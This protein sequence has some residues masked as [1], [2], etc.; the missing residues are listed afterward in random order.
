[1]AESVQ[2]NLLPSETMYFRGKACSKNN[3][4][5]E[6]VDS[7][8]QHIWRPRI[9]VKLLLFLAKYNVVCYLFFQVYGVIMILVPSSA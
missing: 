3:S 4:L 7:R 2:G 8:V 1:M 9:V 5:L 6:R